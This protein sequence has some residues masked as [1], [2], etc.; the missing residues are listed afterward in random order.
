MS[1]RPKL[2]VIIPV[3]KVEPY[4]QKCID[5]ILNQTFRDLELILVD[6]GSPDNCP[7]ICDAA[8]QKDERVVVFHRKN[9]GLSA[10]RNAGLM[11]ARS[12]Y[13]GF[14]DSDDYI[15][16]EMYEKLYAAM[17]ENDAQLAICN[18]TYVDTEGNVLSQ[19]ESPILNGGGV[20]D[21]VQMMDRLGGD[22][23]WYYVTAW[24]KLYRRELFEN[25]RFPFGKLH[26]DEYVVHHVF[27]A[28]ER[29]VVLPESFY[30]YVQRDGSIMHQETL[31]R[32]LDNIW[33]I[34]DRMDFAQEHGLHRL[35][36]RSCN[37][38]LNL[39]THITTGKVK[40]AENERHLYKREK[41]RI[42]GR[43][44]G[45]MWMPHYEEYKIRV[46]LYLVSPHLCGLIIDLKQRR[47]KWRKK[48]C[49]QSRS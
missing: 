22:R 43:L 3:Y 9:G 45:L 27:W 21:R 19:W 11:A 26:E 34:F 30:Y 28:C 37:K 41:A 32:Y 6:D 46:L 8:A 14:V 39:L 1:S 47:K 5:S 7:A 31:R 10:A 38:L 25:I 15:A 42:R 29:I 36:F 24:N 44:W 49:L 23:S 20:L 4:L 35:A 13:I 17:V 16:P 18:Y 33:G 48:Q 2:S 40:I 12:D